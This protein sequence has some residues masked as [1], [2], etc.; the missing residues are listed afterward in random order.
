MVE[1]PPMS[2]QVQAKKEITG[3]RGQV[4]G[5]TK[6]NLSPVSLDLR[7]K[8]AA[9][10]GVPQTS[11]K[12]LFCQLQVFS[13]CQDVPGV[14]QDL[15]ATGLTSVVYADL[16]TPNGIGVLVMTEDP[17][18][19]VGTWREVL[20]NARFRSLQRKPEFVMTGRTYAI[21]REKNLEDWLLKKPVRNALNPAWPWAIWYPLRRKS[22]FALLSGEEQGKILHEHAMIGMTYGQLG[23]AAD[24][25]LACHGLNPQDNEFVLGIIG[26][27]LHPLSRLIQDMRK[28][29]QTAKYIQSL[30]PF[31]VGKVLWQSPN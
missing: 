5:G 14:I 22:E 29:Q 2:Q 11:E 1:C 18:V 13:G 31:F 12:R 20:S 23:H 10:D 30:G 16:H 27:E 6:S 4:T 21:G 24:I 9:I 3:N 17:R 7:E 26:P 25:R 19:L 8:G 15:K 28:T